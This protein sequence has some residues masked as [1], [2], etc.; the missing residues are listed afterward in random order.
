MWV[1]VKCL[2]CILCCWKVN[3]STPQPFFWMIGH[4]LWRKH[5]VAVC[6]LDGRKVQQ[7]LPHSLT[8]TVSFLSFLLHE[9]Q[10]VEYTANGRVDSWA[11]DRCLSSRVTL[12]WW[13]CS[14]VRCVPWTSRCWSFSTK[15]LKL[16]ES[17][18]RDGIQMDTTRFRYAYCI[19]ITG[20]SIPVC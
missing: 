19:A 4:H 16:A 18:N 20:V 11:V 17:S 1:L 14:T 8:Q 2:L 6:V 9:G 5:D 10:N 15:P 3:L 7:L 12:S 13:G